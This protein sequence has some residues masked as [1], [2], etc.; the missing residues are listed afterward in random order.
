M[1]VGPCEQLNDSHLINVSHTYIDAIL[2]RYELQ[3][4]HTHPHTHTP[5]THPPIILPP[6][7][8]AAPPTCAL[9]PAVH[10]LEFC[11][12]LCVLSRVFVWPIEALNRER[13]GSQAA[14]GRLGGPA[15]RSR[16]VRRHVGACVLGPTILRDD[17]GYSMLQ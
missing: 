2:S 9:H 1:P 14:A 3:H 6:L 13:V 5:H 15:V 16:Q 8:L 12:G 10:F 7:L 11:C 17:S 4:P